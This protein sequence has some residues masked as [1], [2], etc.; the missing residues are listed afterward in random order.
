MICDCL[1]PI[2]RKEEESAWTIVAS[3]ACSSLYTLDSIST[4]IRDDNDSL[5]SVKQFSFT[6]DLLTA[7]VY[8]RLALNMLRRPR[9]AQKPSAVLPSSATVHITNRALWPM[10]LT[11]TSIQNSSITVS[12]EKP[13]TSSSSGPLG[14]DEPVV[15]RLMS[16]AAG[17]T[18]SPST[19]SDLNRLSSYPL[20]QYLS[21]L[22]GLRRPKYLPLQ[23]TLRRERKTSDEQH[24]LD[25][26][27]L[28]A[29]RNSSLHEIAL[30]LDQGADINAM[31]LT[32][33]NTPLQI[34]I[35]AHQNE[36]SALFLLQYKNANVHVR[37]GKGRT[38][39]HGAV[40]NS[41]IQ[42]TKCLL[43]LGLS[44]T[45]EDERGVTPFNIAVQDCLD[46]SPLLTLVRHAS[47]QTANVGVIPQID[48]SA[49]HRVCQESPMRLGHALTLLEHGWSPSERFRTVSGENTEEVS[50]LYLAIVKKKT[51]LV[52]RMLSLPS[53]VVC[54]DEKH[55][56]CL[57]LLALAMDAGCSR[58]VLLLLH[59]GA[60]YRNCWTALNRFAER[61]VDFA[62]SR[63]L[64]EREEDD[65]SLR[66]WSF[67]VSGVEAE[68]R[69][70]V[71]RFEDI[72][73]PML[74]S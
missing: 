50:P 16:H 23:S 10:T 45:E 29:T 20:N 18:F 73:R 15:L 71:A 36:L 13:M 9:G 51:G 19:L 26:Q 41:R 12:E 3:G 17:E 63:W 60:G 68:L 69:L 11:A 67:P 34:A 4:G 39:L 2:F 44:M 46:S 47:V 42:T 52:E 72:S 58:I 22:A 7:P 1:K 55:G 37:D 56:P 5:C 30:L 14:A 31:S 24:S 35:T 70:S 53:D 28:Y 65:E 62:L 27:L 8:K 54:I 61:R 33:G 38:L 25:R 64:H 59:A 74:V 43:V 40:R 6:N 32:S 57:S 21:F 49:L 66:D 48:P